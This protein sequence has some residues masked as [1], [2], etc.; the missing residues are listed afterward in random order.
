LGPVL[1][2]K[3][4]NIHDLKKIVCNIRLVKQL[5]ADTN[6]I[7]GI[8]T[9]ISQSLSLSNNTIIIGVLH[10]KI[11]NNKETEIFLSD[12][13]VVWYLLNKGSIICIYHY[14]QHIN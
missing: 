7:V 1:F 14:Y 12:D 11:G 3:S 4:T 5:R 8:I 2:N 9:N 10:E 13:A 6:N